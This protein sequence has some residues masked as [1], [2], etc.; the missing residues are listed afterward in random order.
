MLVL[1]AS[2][3]GIDLS[4]SK[5]VQPAVIRWTPRTIEIMAMIGDAVIMLG[6]AFVAF[7][8]RFGDLDMPSGYLFPVALAIMLSL[9]IFRWR[10]LY[11]ID[12]YAHRTPQLFRLLGAQAMVATILLAI[13]FGSKTSADFSRVW[14]LSWMLIGFVG[15]ALSF[16]LRAALVRAAQAKG[17]LRDRVLLVGDP[18]RI[19]SFMGWLFGKSQRRISVLGVI[20]TEGD[21][22]E[23][24]HG[25]DV[26]SGLHHLP[27]LAEDLGP[28]RVILLFNW[29]EQE[30]INA[31]VRA[32]RGLAL[33][34]EL[35]LPRLGNAWVG[36][37]I[38]T[39]DGL[40]AMNLMRAPLSSEAHLIKRIEDYVLA[41]IL[42]LLV[43]PLFLLIAALI[44][45]DSPG[46]VF[47]LQKR[48]GFQKREFSIF[49]FRTMRV[50]EAA[51][52]RQATRDD[53][54]VTRIGRILRATSIDELPQ[55]INVLRGDMS[56][57]G[58]RPHE[59]S[60]NAD[61]AGRIDDYLVRHGIKPGITGW[62]QVNGARGETR[63]LQDMERRLRYDLAYVDNWSLWLDLQILLRTAGVFLFQKNAY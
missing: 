21:S 34:V 54:R 25:C 14:F 35:V 27:R 18:E 13:G 61:Y 15:I 11:D 19:G 17:M 38:K 44:K 37:P 26:Y 48:A 63:T 36:R 32:L 6:S 29:R 12:S 39:L 8:I 55:L 52:F 42:L 47:Y 57:V 3:E 41:G 24:S 20:A 51:A 22:L 53:N 28:D 23:R 46:P 56:L 16:L 9:N 45:L 2:Q 40:L 1:N 59:V 7:L 31:C 58:P 43:S 62:A 60:M 5:R 49:K 10:R 4:R 30:D 50:E 33:D